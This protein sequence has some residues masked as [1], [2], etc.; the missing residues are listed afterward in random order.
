MYPQLK[1]AIIE[2]L[3]NE[4]KLDPADISE[5]MSFS[6]DLHLDP[7]READLFQRLQ[8]ALNFTLPEDKLTG[9]AT[10]GDLLD[11]ISPE[12]QDES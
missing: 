6:S 12:P 7:D 9:I 3:A 8:D 2:F 1:A 11:A 4:F 10:V 5:E